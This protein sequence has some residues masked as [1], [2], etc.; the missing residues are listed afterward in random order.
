MAATKQKKSGGGKKVAVAKPAVL[1]RDVTAVAAA[2]IATLVAAKNEVNAAKKRRASLWTDPPRFRLSREKMMAFGALLVLV[3]TA[4]YWAVLGAKIQYGNADQL[5]DSYL[6][7]SQDTFAGAHFPATH[8]FL[9]KWPLFLVGALLGNTENVFTVLTVVTSL[10]T[11]LLLAWVLHRIVRNDRLWAVMVLALSLVLLLIP[12][13][14]SPGMWLPV[15]LAMITTR[16]LEYIVFIGALVASLKAT[17]T[18]RLSR[19]IASVVSVRGIVARAATSAPDA[20]KDTSETGLKTHK[21]RMLYALFSVFLWG[22]LFASDRLFIPLAVGSFGMLLLVGL[23]TRRPVVWHSAGRGIALVVVGIA[24]ALGV[25]FALQ[26]ATHLVHAGTASPYQFA[27][28]KQVVLGMV[29]AALALL[30][31]LGLNPAPG[32]TVL[33]D[34]PRA[35]ASEL[36]GLPGLAYLGVCICVVAALY[37]SLRKKPRTSMQQMVGFDLA[38]QLTVLMIGALVV[39]LGLFIGTDHYYAGDA[40]YLSI[41]FFTACITAATLLRRIRM[42]KRAVRDYAA[43]FLVAIIAATYVCYGS[44]QKSIAAARPYAARNER[45]AQVLQQ[46]PVQKLVGDYWRVLPVRAASG[47]KQAVMPLQTCS[48]EREV[49]TSDAWR[50]R[51][52]ESFAYLLSLEKGST[53][54]P[55]CSFG[56]VLKHF[57]RPSGSFVVE[58]T[59]SAPKEMLLFYDHGLPKISHANRS[60]TVE[61]GPNSLANLSFAECSKGTILQ[62]VAHPDDDLLFMNPALYEASLSGECIRTVY[63]TAGDSG[64]ALYYWLGRQIGVESA[65]GIM[66]GRHASWHSQTV[67]LGSAQFATVSTIRGNDRVALVFMNLPDGN[68]GGEGF[69]VTH[70]ESLGKLANHTI[71]SMQSVDLQSSYTAADVENALKQLIE[72]FHPTEVRSLAPGTGTTVADH[73]DHAAVGQIVRRVLLGYQ[74][75]WADSIVHTEYVG[76][77]IQELPQN[78]YDD[79]LHA[80]QEMFMAYAQHDGGVCKTIESCY[81]HSAYG[82]YLS[83]QY[84]FTEYLSA[85][86]YRDAET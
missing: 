82:A 21:A 45:I 41:S 6:F 68:F 7:S 5:V 69:P 24:V 51:R 28:P 8:S 42:S 80:K 39:S 26:H 30:T 85:T 46:H 77:P 63:V 20:E 66:L 9:L 53:D 62:I 75:D 16:N 36:A 4:V 3:A 2:E 70:H 27:A 14:A 54:F 59:V 18:Y 34:W 64:G 74:P 13:E 10:V 11:V 72:T 73:S 43:L 49:L 76:Y 71:S 31:N 78:V 12:A 32:T 25:T 55:V 15:G 60:E 40:R 57:G 67:K 58:G 61:I 29:Y 81:E 48:E 35:V 47:N 56:E 52:G 19:T 37:A 23:C 84:T 65:Y 44:Y 22:V 79:S 38:Q 17:S 83:R 50:L 86:Q 33:G 1:T